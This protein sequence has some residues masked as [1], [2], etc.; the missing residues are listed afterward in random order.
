MY[1]RRYGKVGNLKFNPF[2]LH[3]GNRTVV[4]LASIFVFVFVSF[5]VKNGCK[6]NQ[7]KSKISLESVFEVEKILEKRIFKR[8]V[9]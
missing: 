5:T 9:N 3:C 4:H 2:S 7:K 8:K 6:K 1:V